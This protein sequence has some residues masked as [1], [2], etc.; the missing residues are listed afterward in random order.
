MK[1]TDTQA[2]RVT[3][4]LKGFDAALRRGFEYSPTED[5]KT[6]T[7]AKCLHNTRNSSCTETISYFFVLIVITL[8]C[9]D[10]CVAHGNGNGNGIAVE[11][12]RKT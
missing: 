8:S 1:K 12:T 7:I 10:T 9:R 4:K 11:L 6:S 3:P 2:T 5:C